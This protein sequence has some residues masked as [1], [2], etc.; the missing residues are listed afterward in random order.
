MFRM[1]LRRRRS[2]PASMQDFILPNGRTLR[3]TSEVATALANHRQDG[4]TK[5][6]AGGMLFARFDHELITVE[7]AT[8]PTPFDLRSRFSFQPSLANQRKVIGKQFRNG[9]HFIGEWHTHP[10]DHP[11]PSLQDIETAREFLLESK[12][13]LNAFL[14]VIMGENGALAS[15]WVGVVTT[16]HEHR[17]PLA[18]T[19]L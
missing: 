9:L 6:E 2:S 19:I 4:P 3:F 15:A 1:F 17:L 11:Q 18:P 12:H 10:Q 5:G 13:E 7:E 16:S 8:S 14:V